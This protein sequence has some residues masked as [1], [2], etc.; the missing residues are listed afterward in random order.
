[1]QWIEDVFLDPQAA[2]TELLRLLAEG[3][4]AIA[5]DVAAELRQAQADL[6]RYSC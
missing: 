5:V 2:V 6:H 1:V 4:Q 3:A